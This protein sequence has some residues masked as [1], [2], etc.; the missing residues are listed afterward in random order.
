MLNRHI[1]L[2]VLEHDLNVCPLGAGRVA[3]VDECAVVV[4]ARR[5]DPDRHARPDPKKSLLE[6]NMSCECP[7][8]GRPIR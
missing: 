1:E 4:G 2:P 7:V 3:D 6:F 8:H 5:R